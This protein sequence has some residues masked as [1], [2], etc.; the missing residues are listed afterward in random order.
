MLT[1]S[2]SVNL[3]VK[4]K[5]ERCFDFLKLTEL[6]NSIPKSM[7]FLTQYE[8][9]SRKLNAKRDVI[10]RVYILDLEELANRDDLLEG[11]N[12][13]SDPYIK[14]FLEN[15]DPENKPQGDEKDYQE[16][17]RNAKWAKYYE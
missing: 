8:D 15:D 2:N 11:Q 4:K 16:N 6:V 1:K 12:G 17:K 5:N 9:L 10:V 7:N 13:M 14:I 3:N